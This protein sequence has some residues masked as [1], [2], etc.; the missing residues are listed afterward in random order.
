MADTILW[1]A[2]HT[3]TFGGE[4]NYSWVNRVDFTLA[5]DASRRSIVAAGKA[6]LGLTG[7]RCE[8]TEYGEGYRLRP[9]GSCTVIFILPSY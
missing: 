5:P 4:P 7:C 9:Y 1:H 8:S 6:A 2:E 3:D